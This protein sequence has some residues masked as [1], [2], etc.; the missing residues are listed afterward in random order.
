[1]ANKCNLARARRSNTTPLTPTVLCVVRASAVVVFSLRSL[2]HS[3]CIFGY[4]DAVDARFGKSFGWLFSKIPQFCYFQRCCRWGS[5]NT[6]CRHVLYLHK[7]KWKMCKF[8]Q[9]PEKLQT[10][11][12]RLTSDGIR[13]ASQPFQEL[14]TRF[15]RSLESCFG[16]PKK[17][18]RTYRR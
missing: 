13:I 4:V 6:V 5:V 14:S 15:F 2:Y 11:T 10:S 1:M 3:L 18:L 7:Y 17:Q 9:R 8:L 12:T 16:N